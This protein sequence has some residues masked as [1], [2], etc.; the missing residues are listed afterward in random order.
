MT[1]SQEMAKAQFDFLPR[2]LKKKRLDLAPVEWTVI[3]SK[4][5][6]VHIALD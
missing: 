1:M 3:L 4:Q 5:S 2:F 6:V